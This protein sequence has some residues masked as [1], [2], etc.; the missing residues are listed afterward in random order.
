LAIA[1][2]R[3]ERAD[4][5]G[6]VDLV[7]AE[8]HQIDPGIP[9]RR[10]LF[11]VTL[12]GID[13][14]PDLAP[15]QPHEY[16]V[17]RLHDTGFV[18][19]VH[20]AHEKSIWPQRSLDRRSTDAPGLVRRNELDVEAPPR[21]RRQR[22]ENGVMFD[23]GRDDVAV[24]DRDAVLG[25]SARLFASVA[26][27]VKITSPR[28]APATAATWSL[29]RST[30]VRARRPYSCVRLPALPTSSKWRTTSSRTRASIGVV[31]AQSR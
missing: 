11:A 3:D 31:A 4:A 10:D 22:F 16:L 18:V 28:D 2:A 30:A 6:R 26:P 12:R 14:N 9:Q 17:D 27:L 24:A 13:V 23:L 1:L 15:L 25:K 7:T 8:T 21:Q 5:D 20:D 19:D 29:A